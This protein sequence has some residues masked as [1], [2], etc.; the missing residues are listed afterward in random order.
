VNHIRRERGRKP[1]GKRIERGNDRMGS[2]ENT[3]AGY[4]S[5]NHEKLQYGIGIITT[6]STDSENSGSPMP[7]TWP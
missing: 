6:P 5:T 3:G 4:G 7:L 1:L 2:G